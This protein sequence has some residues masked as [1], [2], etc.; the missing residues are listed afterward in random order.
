MD[1]PRDSKR[2]FV[3]SANNLAVEDGKNDNS[4]AEQ[5]NPEEIV[6][7][8]KV[9]R[10]A[11]GNENANNLMNEMR[12]LI[13]K[14]EQNQIDEAKMWRKR[15]KV[16]EKVHEKESKMMR[17][18]IYETSEKQEIGK[19]RSA[20]T[21]RNDPKVEGNYYSLELEY[22]KS[23]GTFDDKLKSLADESELILKRMKNIVEQSIAN[24]TKQQNITNK[25]NINCNKNSKEQPKIDK[26]I[27]PIKQSFNSPPNQ[28][29]IDMNTGLGSDVL[30]AQFGQTAKNGENSIQVYS[31]RKIDQKENK[32][33]L[34]ENQS[35][36]NFVNKVQMPSKNQAMPVEGI[37]QADRGRV[38]FR[39]KIHPIDFTPKLN[40]KSSK[41]GH[42]LKDFS[43]L[44]SLSVKPK[45][46][47]IIPKMNI[48]WFGCFQLNWNFFPSVKS[49]HVIWR[50]ALSFRI[51][52][53]FAKH[54]WT[55]IAKAEKTST[56]VEHSLLE[57][58]GGCH[59]LQQSKLNELPPRW[60]KKNAARGSAFR[61]RGN[62]INE[63][64]TT[65]LYFKYLLSFYLYVGSNVIPKSQV[66][67]FPESLFLFYTHQSINK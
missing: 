19:S 44:N 59:L 62:V 27:P 52:V 37:L 31:S 53:N 38:P 17:P 22:G 45:F 49:K 55:M 57:Q 29:S 13:A 65:R 23:K 46:N 61:G 16:C 39:F 58:I 32:E 34:R 7:A 63:E 14:M 54:D 15:S 56:N 42:F 3:S 4:N 60:M 10:S 25:K 11:F 48:I 20:G 67:K 36:N 18:K 24:N 8:N 35:E 1:V 64:K 43:I 5:N 41:F 51:F 28:Q 12:T 6:A 26:I 40:I 33:K 47:Q 50:P 9:S 66:E 21:I 2:R 30:H